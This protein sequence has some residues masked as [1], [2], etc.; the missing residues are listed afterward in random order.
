M[1]NNAPKAWPKRFSDKVKI[2]APDE[3]WEWQAVLI[4]NGYGQ[5]WYEGRMRNSH[6]MALEF[7]GALI[8]DDF[9]VMHSCDNRKCCNPRHLSMGV[10]ARNIDDMVR[11]NRG[12][13][14]S[15]HG[16]S[17]LTEANVIAILNS[18]GNAAKEAIR[19][20]VSKATIH[21]IRQG[22]SWRHIPR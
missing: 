10:Q 14:G 19:Y 16:C 1:E 15:Q 2:T 18:S 4:P 3:C 5:Y 13:K 20:G 6:R 9:V 7:L 17:I 11:K 12:A 22:I 8:P 21:D